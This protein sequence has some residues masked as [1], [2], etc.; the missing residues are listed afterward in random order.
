MLTLDTTP[1]LACGATKDLSDRPRCPNLPRART[2]YYRTVSNHPLIALAAAASILVGPELA[3]A[4][5][6]HDKDAAAT[7]QPSPLAFLSGYF[8]YERPK[9][10]VVEETTP[11]LDQI[12]FRSRPRQL[13]EADVAEL[14]ATDT[15]AKPKTVGQLDIRRLLFKDADGDV[16]T[17]LLCTPSGKTGP[18]PL[19]IA[20]HGL[21]SNKAQVCGQVAPALAKKGFAVLAPDMPVHG[22]RPGSPWELQRN[23]DWLRAI[24]LHRR[25]IIDIR[26]CIDLAEQRDDLDVSKGVVLAGYSMGAWLHSVAGPIDPRVRAMVLMVG[27]AHDL[28]HVAPLLRMLP[29]AAAANPLVA[30]PEFGRPLLML[31]GRHDP[32]VTPDMAQR[33]YDAA[34]EPKSLKWYNS[35]H[36]LP[37]RAYLD[38]A[39][40]IASMWQSLPAPR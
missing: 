8:Q 2:Y 10:I 13:R 21:N 6:G 20:V 37:E 19:A 32:V 3:H 17:A 34:A 27:G 31:N 33:L 38:A 15:P 18:F 16:V 23:K 9:K 1:A 26:Q 28:A 35:G 40:W 12:N 30:L 25:A 22:E 7:S 5:P 24:Q 11:T 14:V 29:Q 4:Q 39:D 36:L